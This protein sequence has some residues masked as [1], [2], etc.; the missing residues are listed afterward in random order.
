MSNLNILYKDMPDDKLEFAQKTILE[1]FEKYY[2][3]RVIAQKIRAEFDKNYG[4]SWCC[5]V[6]RSFGSHV[7][8]QTGG[9]LFCNL[10]KEISVLLWKTA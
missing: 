3:E 6:G 4:E 5:I 7:I 1:N 10:N 2:Q 9:Y 8:H